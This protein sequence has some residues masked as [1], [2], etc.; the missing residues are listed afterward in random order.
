M[1]VKPLHPLFVAVPEGE[2]A[3]RACAGWV[4]HLEMLHAALFG[5]PMKFPFDRF[6]AAREA[7][8]ER[9]QG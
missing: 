8:K 2:D 3:A 4:A 5:V 9:L 7:Y 1:I 6:K